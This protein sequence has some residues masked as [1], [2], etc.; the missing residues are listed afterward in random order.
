MRTLLLIFIISIFTN[1]SYSQE[2][3]FEVQFS[4]NYATFEFLR[5]LSK[6]YPDNP[7]KKVFSVSGY[8]T[9]KNKELI[10]NFNNVNY[11]YWYEYEQYPYGNKIGGSTFFIL[12]RNL[13]ETET[14]D[15]FKKRSYGIIPNIDLNMISSIISE[16]KPI[17][18]ELVYLPNKEKFLNQ[19]K[20]VKRLISETDVDSA[21]KKVLYFHN[22]SWDDS[23][24]F[25]TT[26][27]P[28]PDNRNSGF[29]ATAFYNHA[30]GGIPLGLSNYELLLS[31]MFH[32]AYHILYD[33]QSLLFK[34]QVSK[35]FSNN[36]SQVS[37]YAQLLFNEAITT[38]LANGYLF[39]DFKG[40]MMDGRW[41]NNKYISKMAKSLYPIV[42][43]YLDGEKQIDENFINRYISIFE[44]DYISWLNELDHLM[45][46]RFIITQDYNAYK[47][48]SKKYRYNN[49]EEHKNKLNST[50]LNSVKTYPIT[51]VILVTSNNEESIEL[52][53]NTFLDLKNWQP[54]FKKNFYY[55]QFLKDKTYLILINVTDNRINEYLDK[56]NLR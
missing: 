22:S 18:N 29:T 3:K 5:Y 42:K 24:P 32:E 23:I 49:I 31:V 36:N 35:W 40:K 14:I 26:L 12:G 25:T 51:K 41:Y 27:Y 45:M 21:F 38:S 8:N 17:Y 46:N 9:E 50:T 52:I 53:K 1:I 2:I 16:F 7:F 48:I 15:E 13:L 11:F 37:Q 10:N 30:V 6:N 34:K 20:N 28:I 54:N 55:K 44:E 4:E 33:E 39:K 19:L 43:E 47:A 56:I